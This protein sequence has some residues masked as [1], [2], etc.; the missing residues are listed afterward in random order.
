MANRLQLK[1]L[2]PT[3]P[4]SGLGTD[5]SECVELLMGNEGTVEE[6]AF[7]VTTRA[8]AVQERKQERQ[9][10][11]QEEACDVQPNPLEMKLRSTRMSAVD[12]E[13]VMGW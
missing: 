1:Q 9:K 2:S 7:A 3:L 8:Q 5:V 10:R 4:L 13:E 6:R 12:V 11:M